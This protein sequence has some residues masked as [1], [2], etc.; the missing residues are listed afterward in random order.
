VEEVL[1]EEHPDMALSLNNLA[2]LYDNQ[3]RYAE[4]EPLYQRALAIVEKVLGEEHPSS[5]KVKAN[6]KASRDAQKRSP[7]GNT[8]R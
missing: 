1:G 3:G 6:Y 5:Q 4:A 7:R 2:A 8:D